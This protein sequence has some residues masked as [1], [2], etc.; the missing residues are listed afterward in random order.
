MD[1]LLSQASLQV[2][3]HKKLLIKTIDQIAGS[4]IRNKPMY[5]DE[6]IFALIQKVDL[7]EKMLNTRINYLVRIRFIKER[8]TKDG[9]TLLQP[10]KRNV[11]RYASKDTFYDQ[12]HFIGYN[13][14]VKKI[15]KLS[16]KLKLSERH[17][18]IGKE[19]A[20]IIGC[21]PLFI[22]NRIANLAPAIV[23]TVTKTYKLPVTRK[24]ISMAAGTSEPSMTGLYHKIIISL[25]R[26]FNR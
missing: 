17:L 26:H 20:H 18:R 3:F 11:L 6:L 4:I 24:T 10:T 12:K 5:K 19:I 15:E 23:Y 1:Y 14:L 7:S 2:P 9:R 13:T 16:L 21:D 22:S 8:K 25:R